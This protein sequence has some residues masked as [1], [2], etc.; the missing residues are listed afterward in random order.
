MKRN[1][2]LTSAFLLLAASCAR[3]NLQR[4]VPGS[5]QSETK[6]IAEETPTY[7]KILLDDELTSL[8]EDQLASGILRTKSDALNSVTEE[9]GVES[10]VRLFPF[11]GE[12]EPRTRREGLH[13]WY[14]VAL[15]TSASVTKAVKSFQG[16][17]GVEYVEE[18]IP[19]KLATND[20]YWSNMW[21]LNNTSYPGYD[22][23]C[24]PVW[25]EFTTGNPNV[26]VAVIDGGIQLDHPD[27]APNCVES[28]HYNYVQGNAEIVPH[29]HG[30]HVAGTIAAASN[31]GKGVTGIAGGN[32]AKGR[33]GVKLLSQQVFQEY[34][35]G[36]SR[37]GDFDAAIKEAA[38]KG[39]VICQN[40]WGYV[41]DTDDNGVISS[42]ELDYARRMF[43]SVSYSSIARAMDYFIKY[44][45][46]DNN[47]NQ[48]PGSPMKGGL[49]VFS[50]GNDNIQYGIPGCYSEA[51]AV[52]AITQSG[53][54]TSFSNYGDWVDLCAPGS[55]VY[56]T[57][58]ND[59]YQYLSGTSMACPH[60]SG[61]AAL[62]VSYLGGQGFTPAELKKRLLEGARQVSVS[63][64]SKPIGPLVDAFN[65]FMVGDNVAPPALEN[66]SLTTQGHNVKVNFT[67]NNAYGHLVLAA[68]T[69]KAI[70]NANLA[71]PEGNGLIAGRIIISE[72]S[73]RTA[74]QEY[75]LSG[76]VPDSDYYVA[77]ASYSYNRRYSPLSEIK[78]VHTNANEKPTV[79]IGHEGDFQFRNYQD[80]DIPF[81]IYDPDEDVLT[82]D[83]QTDGRASFTQNEDGIWHFKLSC[84]M[85]KAPASFSASLV[86][87]DGFGG[88][89]S[90]KIPYNVLANVAPVLVGDVP[91][92]LLDKAGKSVFID[93]DAYFD[94][95]DGE[96]LIYRVVSFDKSVLNAEIADNHLTVTPKSDALSISEIRV[97]AF[98]N[99]GASARADISVLVRPEGE[100]V[101][102]LEGQVVSD[103]LTIIPDIEPGKVQIRIVSVS[104]AVVY[105]TEGVYSAFNPLSIDIRSLAPGIYT[106]IV[107]D[108]SG[109]ET[110]YTIVKR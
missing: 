12:F 3:E 42:S 10:M 90:L 54:R 44:A 100:T 106:V 37:S 20:T 73:E 13:R 34:P 1:I 93:L 18:P 82:V 105:R 7:I 69:R 94:D 28:G 63:T 52:G 77:V 11:A 8:V 76:L 15:P 104:G 31:N 36:T 96:S 71:N 38:D 48:L 103:K 62:I 9:L 78:Q 24:M 72:E 95:E 6:L 91:K 21:N 66:F 22:I 49:V 19:A 55:R 50:A 88:R 40:S 45:G 59:G 57:D 51:L 14:K 74:A 25:E 43:E 83:F 2:L 86:V 80:I 68:P 30:T 56:S 65:S 79:S 61:V 32:Y 102:L 60:V 107:T 29:Y 99:M 26:V 101:S 27:L 39:A 33:P 75:V 110:K 17:P 108:A 58:V 85:V 35:N 53:Q 23:D 67:G 97:T 84:Q 98:D 87:A 64:G 81:T 47:G 41:I 109:K 70:E 16:L 92:I 89:V 46:C 5:E 4:F